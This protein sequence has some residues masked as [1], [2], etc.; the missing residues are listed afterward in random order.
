MIRAVLFCL[1]VLS[2]PG[3]AVGETSP[4]L[5]QEHRKIKSLSQEEIDGLLAGKGMGYAKAAELNGIPGPAHVLEL[6]VELRLSRQQKEKT[7]RLFEEMLASAKSLGRSL[8]D[9]EQALDDL[10]ARAEAT[11][12]T[13]TRHLDSIARIEARLRQVHLQAHL[14]QLEV[15]GPKQLALYRE[16]RGYASEH[17]GHPMNH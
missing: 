2:L 17:T 11:P 8:V 12:D 10:F 1:S 13:L 4:Y 15:L 9:A 16:F 5:G 14:A 3:L 6:A 7:E